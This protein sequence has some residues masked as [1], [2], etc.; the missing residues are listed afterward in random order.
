L[1]VV[2]AYIFDLLK[3]SCFTGGT[4]TSEAQNVDRRAVAAVWHWA[5]DPDPLSLSRKERL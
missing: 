2:E 3:T 1:Q 5:L 4:D